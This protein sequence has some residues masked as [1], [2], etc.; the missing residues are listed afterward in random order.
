GRRVNLGQPGTNDYMLASEILRYLRLTPTVAPAKGDYTLSSLSK[1]ELSQL[2]EKLQSQTGA[3]RQASVEDLPDVVITV[4]S[5][6]GML[7]QTL[8]DTGAF[9]LAPFPHV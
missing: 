9:T 8:L 4:A 3:Q 7:V 6:P 2:A 5:L 1:E